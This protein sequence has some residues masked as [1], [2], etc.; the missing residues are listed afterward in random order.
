VN[1]VRNDDRSALAGDV[2]SGPIGKLAMATGGIR[3]DVTPRA[4]AK[5]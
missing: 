2:M 1:D 3:P 5:P 4:A